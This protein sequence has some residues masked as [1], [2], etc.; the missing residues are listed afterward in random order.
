M[1]G[2]VTGPRLLQ[3]LKVQADLCDIGVRRDARW[4]RRVPSMTLNIGSVSLRPGAGLV[5]ERGKL[6]KLGLGQAHVLIG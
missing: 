5:N 1:G 2:D 4:G 6:R 3:T